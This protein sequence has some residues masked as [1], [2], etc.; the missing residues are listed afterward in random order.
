MD[1]GAVGSRRQPLRL[2]A[3]LI[4]IAILV[5]SLVLVGFAAHDLYAYHAGTSARATIEQC[6][7]SSDIE[8]PSLTRHRSP[9]SGFIDGVVNIVRNPTGGECTG[10][11]SVGGQSH[12]GPVVV[13]NPNFR[14]GWQVG[15]HVFGGKAYT[16][17]AGVRQLFVSMCVAG[18]AV[19]VFWYRRFGMRGLIPRR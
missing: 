19:L 17:N 18:L 5:V 7:G 9:A 12:S 14:Q 13:D 11:W 10:T 1:Q 8:R 3:G 6:S 16:L 2:V 4:G 15:V